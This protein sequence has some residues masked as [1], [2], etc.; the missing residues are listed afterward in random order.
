VVTDARIAKA[1]IMREKSPP[2]PALTKRRI[3]LALVSR[4]C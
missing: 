3:V 2:T 1:L 4:E